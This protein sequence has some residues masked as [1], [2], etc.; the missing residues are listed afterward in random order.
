MRNKDLSKYQSLEKIP[1]GSVQKHLTTQT[2]FSVL[3]WRCQEYRGT[4]S[5]PG[6]AAAPICRLLGQQFEP[7]D[8]GP[9]LSQVT[10]AEVTALLPG[11]FP[12]EAV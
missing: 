11:T 9:G 4:A 12:R 6:A 3:T 7:P 2:F 5:I 10:L 8:P 1:L